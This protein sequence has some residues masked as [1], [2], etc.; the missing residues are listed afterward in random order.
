MTL[1]SGKGVEGSKPVDSKDKSKDQIEK[2]LEEEG[3]SKL[4][5]EATSNSSFKA[6]TNPPHFSSRLENPKRQNKENEILEVF[7]KV[8]IN[9]PLL[10]AIK[11]VPKYAKF[12]KDLCINRKK[13][14]GDERIMVG[15][16][17]STVLQKKLSPKCGD[18]RLLKETSIIIQLADRINAYV[19]GL[20]KDVLF[21]INELVFPTDFYVLD[22]NDEC[23]LNPS[24]VI[25]GRLF[26]STIETKIDVKQGT[27]TMEFDGEVI[28][29][30]IFKTMKYPLDSHNAFAMSVIDPVIH[31]IFEIDGRDE[32]QNVLTKHFELGLTCDMEL[33]AELKCI[34]G[35]LQSMAP[36][37][38]RYEL[39]PLFIPDSHPKMLRSVMQAP[40]VELKSLSNHL[41][42]A[43]LDDKNTLP[44][45][46]FAKLDPSQE[47]RLIRVLRDHKETIGWI[48]V[49]IKDI[50]P[51]FCMHT[52]RLEEGAKP[53][54]QMQRRLNPL[55]IEI[56]K[57]E[58][59]KL[60]DVGIIYTI[61]NSP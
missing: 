55:M 56:V 30:N 12:L 51:S 43:F 24:H 59:L 29:F 50:I 38:I 46:I 54:R 60:L 61:S 4:T 22:M 53:V 6:N 20:L 11:Q 32:L 45:I 5:P 35:A 3:I 40:E 36:T 33:G 42:Y 48:I 21:K 14:R 52:I 26:F 13:L 47:D 10:D 37:A 39:A 27:L 17:V 2:E 31:E 19:D 34:V 15:E 58:I 44:V 57:K 18:S 49:D 7:R 25:L 28:H 8:E 1:R 16:T 23:S 41:K 9:I